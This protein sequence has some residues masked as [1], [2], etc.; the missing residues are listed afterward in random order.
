MLNP[1]GSIL[2]KQLNQSSKAFITY[3]CQECPENAV[4]QPGKMQAV[5]NFWGY[6]F[7]NRITMLHCPAGYCCQS[8]PC[9][10]YD[11][12][13]EGRE[14][15]LCALCLANYS[16]PFSNDKCVA[17]VECDS[18]LISSYIFLSASGYF[19]LLLFR[20]NLY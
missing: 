5:P 9:H 10:S 2:N 16:L 17:T 12:C 15:L 1:G 13:N 4:C 14:G 8:L 3:R 11:S 7:E 18:R 19:L 20:N 6:M